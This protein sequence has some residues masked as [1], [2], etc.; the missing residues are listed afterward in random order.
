MLFRSLLVAYSIWLPVHCLTTSDWPLRTTAH[1]VILGFVG[2][3]LA[4][5][6]LLEFNLWDRYFVPLAPFAL[7]LVAAPLA[8]ATNW[9]Q[10]HNP[11]RAMHALAVA[12]IALL[13]TV[14][15][16]SL[17]ASASGYALGGDHG[18]YDGIERVA[19]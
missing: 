18:A 2:A 13:A 4:A 10:S 1:L 16:A 17:R 19:A 12:C 3:Y 14:L 11:S 9:L 5:Y 15:P 7:M 8:A 6:W